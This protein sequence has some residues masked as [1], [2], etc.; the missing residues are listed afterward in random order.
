MISL[1][2]LMTSSY[3]ST[4]FL[5]SKLCHSTCFCTLVTFLVSIELCA[6]GSLS[7]SDANIGELKT[8]KSLSPPNILMISSLGDIKN[9]VIPGSHCLPLLHLSW[10]SILLVSCFSV[11]MIASHPASFTHSHSLISVPLHAIL[12]AIVTAHI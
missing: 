9:C 5:I 7:G 8:P 4:C 12:V 10:L 3:S 6:R 2:L 1:C 11:P